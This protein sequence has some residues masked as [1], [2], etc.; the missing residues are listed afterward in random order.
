M[1]LLQTEAITLRRRRTRDA[2]ALVIL[3]GKTSGKVTASTKS[4]MKTK[5]RYAGVTQ[6]FNRIHAMLYAKREEQ[7]IWTLTQVSLIKNYDVIQNNFSRM[8]YASC[9]VEW[10]DF[11]SSE[12]QSSQRV[13]VTLTDALDDWN[14][15]VPGLEGLFYYQ[16]RLLCAAGL[17]PIIA[18]CMA[19]HIKD[20]AAWSYL[21]RDGG[22][23]SAEVTRDGFA[24]SAGTIQ[25]L[26]I[27]ANSDTPPTIKLSAQQK[28]EITT[29]LKLHLEYHAGL[30]SRAGLFLEK[31][32]DEQQNMPIP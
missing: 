21:P 30:K 22:I 6:P 31:W 9:L 24:V 28:R 18:H 4:V 20:A 15:N 2:D 12:F 8:V 16:W 3:Y 1:P 29:L 7:D 32:L 13:W 25:V 5:S 10:I 23:V 26:R 19:T 17:Q 11:L 27:L 14:E